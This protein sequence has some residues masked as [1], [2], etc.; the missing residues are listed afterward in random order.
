M[1]LKN[2][3]YSSS[4]YILDLQARQKSRVWNRADCL[5]WQRTR[6][7]APAVPDLG[8]M[9]G[10]F[11]PGPN[12]G[13]SGEP[14]SRVLSARMRA[15]RYF[16]SGV[17]AARDQGAARLSSSSGRLADRRRVGMN[18]CVLNVVTVQCSDRTLM[19]YMDRSFLMSLARR[20]D[21]V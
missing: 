21:Q 10:W 6:A 3:G 5:V 8:P 20:E 2:E 17:E 7:I 12:R 4:H 13:Y 14:G 19:V 1:G 15:T 11:C 16:I 18:C 9:A